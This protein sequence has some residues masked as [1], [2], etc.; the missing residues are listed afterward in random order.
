MQ[1]QISTPSAVA[2]VVVALLILG[3]AL[4]RF[5]T[6]PAPL[7]LGTPGAAPSR[8]LPPGPR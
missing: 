2:I 7:A 3:V 1:R 6:P 8:A 4:W 5:M